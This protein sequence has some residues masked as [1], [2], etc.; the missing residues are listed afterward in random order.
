MLHAPTNPIRCIPNEKLACIS[1]T[2]VFR[3]GY[4]NVKVSFQSAR[5]KGVLCR[6]IVANIKGERST[7]PN[8]LKLKGH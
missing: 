3:S 7:I 8:H 4:I 5:E 2:F 6:D 1:P